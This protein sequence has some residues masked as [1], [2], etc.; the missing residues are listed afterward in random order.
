MEAGTLLSGA[1]TPDEI[2][3]YDI[4]SVYAPFIEND[5]VAYSKSITAFA[6]SMATQKSLHLLQPIRF[7]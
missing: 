1:R 5:P 4:I 2:T 6:K 7:R 3:M